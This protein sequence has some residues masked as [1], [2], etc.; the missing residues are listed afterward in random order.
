MVESRKFGLFIT[1]M[2]IINT[3]ILATLF[4]GQP[5]WLQNI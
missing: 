2:I 5:Q 3:I 1:S 4:V